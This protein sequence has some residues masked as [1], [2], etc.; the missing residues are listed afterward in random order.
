[1]IILAI[2][3]F[4]LSVVL[5]VGTLQLMQANESLVRIAEALESIEDVPIV[6]NVSIEGM[7]GLGETDGRNE[8]LP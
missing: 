3:I 8:R 1:M 2:S 4:Y 5:A 7:P 6:S